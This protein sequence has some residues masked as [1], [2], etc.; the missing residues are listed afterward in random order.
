MGDEFAED[1]SHR[2]R[3]PVINGDCRDFLFFWGVFKEVGIP[4]A[5]FSGET[6]P[7]FAFFRD[8]IPVFLR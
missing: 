6:D 1:S 4:P 7:F 8:E 3:V 5:K 2:L